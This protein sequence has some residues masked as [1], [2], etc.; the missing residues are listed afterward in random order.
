MVIISTQI[1]LFIWSLCCVL[2]LLFPSV[3]LKP[4]AGRPGFVSGCRIQGTPCQPRKSQNTQSC[5]PNSYPSC[6]TIFCIFSAFPKR[7]SL[8]QAAKINLS[9][10]QAGIY[11]TAVSQ[12]LGFWMATAR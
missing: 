5:N 1:V 2:L 10:G 8:C 6:W 11:T 3:L 7:A 12:I 9:S 4:A